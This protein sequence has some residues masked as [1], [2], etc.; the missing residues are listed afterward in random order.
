MAGK[1]VNAEISLSKENLNF[2]YFLRN[3]VAE[4]FQHKDDVTVSFI[5]HVIISYLDKHR[6]EF[7]KMVEWFLLENK[8]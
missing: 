4:P 3:C 2:V 8:E 6:N 7:I 5:F 1:I